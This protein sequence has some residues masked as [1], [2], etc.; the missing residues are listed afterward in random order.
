MIWDL[1]SNFSLT[2]KHPLSLTSSTSFFTKI[3]I[4]VILYAINTEYHKLFTATP[5]KIT[6]NGEK[7]VIYN[8]IADYLYEG[9]IMFL[10]DKQG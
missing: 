5:E 1:P 4:D 9:K 2:C 6:E 3:K 8:G 7:G 10:I